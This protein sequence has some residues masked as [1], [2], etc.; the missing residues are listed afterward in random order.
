[1]EWMKEI[2]KFQDHIFRPSRDLE[3]KM[4]LK[5]FRLEIQL[6]LV[7]DD[8]ASQEEMYQNGEC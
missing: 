7:L 2:L 8:F 5:G 3:W 6:W 1:M 4:Q